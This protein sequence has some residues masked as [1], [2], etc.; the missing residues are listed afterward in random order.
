MVIAK[1]GFYDPN[2][3]LSFMFSLETIAMLYYGIEDVR[4]FQSKDTRFAAQ[5]QVENPGDITFKPFS[6]FPPSYTHD[7]SFWYRI[8]A[9]QEH[10]NTTDFDESHLRRIVRRIAKNSVASLLCVDVYHPPGQLAV[11]YC[12]RLVY[13]SVDQ[14]VSKTMAGEMQLIIRATLQ[15]EMGVELR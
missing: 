9:S 14:A 10:S 8:P 6:L 12:Y 5:F 3:L 13:S 11:S 15:R 7:I 1:Y 4:L 2:K